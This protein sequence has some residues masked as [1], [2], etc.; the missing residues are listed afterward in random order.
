VTMSEI[1]AVP[2]GSPAAPPG[3]AGP[4]AAARGRSRRIAVRIRLDFWLDVTLLAAYIVAYSF[5][6][7]G[8]AIHEWL[9]LGLGLALLLHLTLHWG[10][11]I[12]T[13][14]R[15]LRR[16]GRDRLLYAVNL[17]LLVIMT[18]CVASGVV[19][20]RVA[21]PELGILIQSSLFWDR[22]HIVT[23]EVTLALVGVHVGLRWRWLTSVG[24]R[25]LG[26][27]RR[28]PRRDPR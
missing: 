9:G 11:V 6:F 24:R 2:P 10:W 3:P 28:R 1:P 8:D 21:L 4:P 18:L 27:P 19:I 15:L 20:S 25:L 23:A 17:A 14:A 16:G 12:R 22:L 13:T 26:G 7:T 5:D